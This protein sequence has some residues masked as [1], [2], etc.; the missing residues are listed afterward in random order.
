MHNYRVIWP[1]DL[2]MRET[3]RAIRRKRCLLFCTPALSSSLMPGYY[4][5]IKTIPQ[6][7][8]LDIFENM[9]DLVQD[10][11]VLLATVS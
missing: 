1:V 2:L 10:I 7:T 11:P 8:F 3:S 4:F 5:S 9:L 6:T